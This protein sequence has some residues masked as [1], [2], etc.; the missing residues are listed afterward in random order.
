M[1]RVLKHPP[2]PPQQRQLYAQGGIVRSEFEYDPAAVEARAA[3]LMDEI[4]A[5]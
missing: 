4:D 2:L 1:I 5:A 3:A